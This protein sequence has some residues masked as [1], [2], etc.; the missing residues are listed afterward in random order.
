MTAKRLTAEARQAVADKWNVENVPDAAAN[1]EARRLTSGTSGL[2]F[3]TVY[4]HKP[5]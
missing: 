1:L 5:A 2:E 4:P 3:P